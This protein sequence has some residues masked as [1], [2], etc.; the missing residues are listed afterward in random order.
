MGA[1]ANNVT[2]DLNNFTILGDGTGA[3]ITSDGVEGFTIRNGTV[4][5]FNEGS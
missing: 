1:A 2:I 5:N 3:G 4:K